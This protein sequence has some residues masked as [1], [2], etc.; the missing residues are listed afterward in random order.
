MEKEMQKCNVSLNTSRSMQCCLELTSSPAVSH[1]KSNTRTLRRNTR[2]TG[3]ARSARETV[4]SLPSRR[5]C[6]RPAVSVWTRTPLRSPHPALLRPDPLYRRSGAR[7]WWRDSRS[8]SSL[9]WWWD[10]P[11]SD[12]TSNVIV[13]KRLT[14]TTMLHFRNNVFICFMQFTDQ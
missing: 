3:A 10:S 2:W 8:P 1:S 4:C 9:L 12:I 13:W 6:Y 5:P 14:I 11:S 7:K